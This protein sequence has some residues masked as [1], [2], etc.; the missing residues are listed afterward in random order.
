MKYR[1]EITINGYLEVEASSREEAEEIV[2]DGY[3]LNDLTVVDDDIDG[4]SE[5]EV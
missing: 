2:E 3:S 5:V 1:V 4:I